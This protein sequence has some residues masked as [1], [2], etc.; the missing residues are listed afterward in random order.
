MLFLSLIQRA[1]FAF[2]IPMAFVANGAAAHGAEVD[3]TTAA[4]YKAHYLQ[5]QGDL[6]EAAK[7]YADV[8][9]AKRI[10]G[11]IKNAAQ[12]GLAECREE[13][14]C[15]DFASLMPEDALAYIEVSRPGK[16]I[17]DLL[18]MLGLLSD[19]DN[20]WA[21]PGERYLAI[22]PVLVNELAGI[23]GV[24]VAITGVD[25]MAQAPAGVA[26]L[27][28]G[29]VDAIRGAL[30]TALP[31]AAVS[32]APIAG[33][34]TYIIEDKV[35]VC[36]TSRLIVVSAQRAQIESVI[37][38]L[39]GTDKKSLANSD[40]MREV[41]ASRGKSLLFF[42]V[43]AKPIV[44]M[45][46]MMGAASEELAVGN[47]VLDLDSFKWIS[48]KLGVEEDGPQLELS[49]CYEEGQQNLAYNLLRTPP[50]S[51]DILASIPKGTAGFI[52]SA[53][54]ESSGKTANVGNDRANRA[55]IGLDFGREIFAN[56]VDFAVCVVPPKEGSKSS[57]PAPDVAVVIRVNDPT[58]SEKLWQQVLGLIT[59]AAGAPTNDGIADAIAGVDMRAYR[60]PENVNVF[61]ATVGDKV[62]LATSR[63]AAQQSIE[64]VQGGPSVLD[65]DA[66]APGI[67]RMTASTSKAILVHPKR[68]LEV[69]ARFMNDR[70]RAE[71]QP[72]H[73]MIGDLVVAAM[74]DESDELFRLSVS[75]SSLPNIGP[76]VAAQLQR[77]FESERMHAELNTASRQ[78]NWDAALAVLDK[79]EASGESNTRLDQKR[80]EILA[81]G[82][83]NRD[84]V[85]AAAKAFADKNA[86]HPGA[87]NQLAWSL[88]TEDKF[89]SKYNDVALEL[90]ELACKASNN[91]N[92]AILD[93]AALANFKTG[94]VERALEL[95]EQ[96][97]KQGGGNSKEVKD[98]LEEYRSAMAMG[99]APK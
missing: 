11:E 13:L 67:A 95:Q 94:N 21:K 89:E 28:P 78:K 51:R 57:S 64:T 4:F 20:S 62:I 90:A 39:N 47:A 82:K 37:N 52:T 42:C 3:P 5:Q 35:Y 98:R 58:K 34:P 72:I 93:T 50:I 32:V 85:A 49:V 75:A 17:G 16:Q 65:D 45:I 6:A 76:M 63:H 91:S 30:E 68:C 15:A 24:A 41:L 74:T 38:R 44:P 25:P 99:N 87:L 12:Q 8:L 56:I 43:N 7:L 97:V 40:A 86:R 88:L 22:S 23:R 54:G 18:D 31:A 70:E 83:G 73:E 2:V 61:F 48:G 60:F 26:V 59:M 71:V 14:A 69:A 92:W 33:R 79:L 19:G 9:Q 36:L 96:A 80:I 10:D 81:A 84:Q 53:L 46:K 29:S 1:V 27:H 55:V 77:E 66:F